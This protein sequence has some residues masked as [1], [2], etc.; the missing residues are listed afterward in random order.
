MKYSNLK[1]YKYRLESN[2]C[3][4]TGITGYSYNG[5][6]FSLES[7][8]HVV[9][10]KGYC[11]D[12]ASG[13]TWDSPCTMRGSLIHDVLYQLIRLGVIPI[14]FKDKAD[15]LLRIICI[16]NGMS[17]TRADLWYWAVKKFGLM[18]WKCVP[19]KEV[20]IISV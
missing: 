15:S 10:F 6:Y 1:N 5:Q 20:E 2:E 13:P 8:G 18:N 16:A 12:G 14:E 17:R 7:N 19:E 9:V 3:F 4:I 11:W